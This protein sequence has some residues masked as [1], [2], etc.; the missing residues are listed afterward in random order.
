[1][2]G[3]DKSLR[4]EGEMK[5]RDWGRR[6][7]IQKFGKKSRF[8]KKKSK[9]FLLKSKLLDFLRVFKEKVAFKAKILFFRIFCKSSAFSGDNSQF[10]RP[11]TGL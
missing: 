11:K 4:L 9:N 10:F 6:G 5:I 8:I 7:I 1:M 3:G 2:Q